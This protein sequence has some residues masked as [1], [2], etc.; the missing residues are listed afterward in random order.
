MTKELSIVVPVYNEEENLYELYERLIQV[1]SSLKLTYEIILVDDGSKDHSFQ[2]IKK[3]ASENTNIKYIRFTRNFGHQSALFAG[4]EKVSGKAI[5]LMD[6]DLQDPPEEIREL[7]TTLHHGYDVVY[8]KRNSRNG[9]RASKKISAALF[10][11]I[12][13]KITHFNIP[14]DTGDFRIFTQ[15]VA[16][17]LLEMNDHAKF[18]RGQIAWLGFKEHFILY[19]REKRK[20]GKSNFG[21]STM[22]RFAIDGITGF[23][24]FPLKFASISGLIVSAFSFLMIIY[25]LLAKFIW[26]HTITGWTSLMVTILFLGG[27]QLLSIGIIGEYISRINDGVKNRKPYIVDQT[28]FN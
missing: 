26:H 27:I 24:N 12:L 20:K 11:R 6:G 21:F 3:I 4:I 2:V 14:V 15:R 9:E 19:E 7:W 18:L 22:M 13:N 28:N 25:V 8:A 16:K 1:L 23:S 10:Y 17:E 5:V